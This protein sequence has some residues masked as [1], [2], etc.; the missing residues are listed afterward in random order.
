M[1]EL[2]Q[3]AQDAA[4]ESKSLSDALSG[5]LADACQKGDFTP[6]QLQALRNALGNCKACQRAM[7]AKLVRV[8]LVDGGKLK[9]CDK[10]CEGQCD[11]AE[12]VAALCDCKDRGQLATATHDGR[13]G[14][15]R[16]GRTARRNDLVGRHKAGGCRVQGKSAAAGGRFLAER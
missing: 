8:K 4:A 11:E 10:C 13:Q 3:M 1:K 14:R 16:R 15:T 12:L 6:E 7:I 5:D 2:A 9:L